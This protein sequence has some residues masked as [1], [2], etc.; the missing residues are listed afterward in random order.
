MPRPMKPGSVQSFGGRQCS[1]VRMVG[2]P[3]HW[4]RLPCSRVC[5]G[6]YVRVTVAAHKPYDRDTD[7]VSVANPTAVVAHHS[8]DRAVRDLHEA[9]VGVAGGGGEGDVERQPV[10]LGA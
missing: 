5:G 1:T 10:R 8:A 2:R 4:M 3:E 7:D 9:E 6:V